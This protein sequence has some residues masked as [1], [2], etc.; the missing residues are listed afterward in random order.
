MDCLC[1]QRSVVLHCAILV[2]EETTA[3]SLAN[4]RWFNDACQV[5]I[6]LRFQAP[7]WTHHSGPSPTPFDS[8]LPSF[9]QNVVRFVGGAR[10]DGKE[11]ETY[12]SE[13][14]FF[15]MSLNAPAIVVNVPRKVRHSSSFLLRQQ[16]VS[17]FLVASSLLHRPVASFCC[18]GVLLTG[19]FLVLSLGLFLGLFSSGGWRTASR[20]SLWS[21]RPQARCDFR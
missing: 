9:G 11:P 15:P 20:S 8:R 13:Q 17:F 21:R 7:I 10:D 1:C 14:W 2:F 12:T 4:V 6:D 3:V 5:R 18:L 16:F 19:L